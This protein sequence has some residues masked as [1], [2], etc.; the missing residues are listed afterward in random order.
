M[1]GVEIMSRA[2]LLNREII[3]VAY[4]LTVGC[5]SMVGWTSVVFGCLPM[6]GWTSVVFGCLKSADRP[7]LFLHLLFFLRF[8]RFL[9]LKSP[10]FF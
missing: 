1:F 10:L 9:R 8:S 4:S 3:V 6:V 5:V 7:L 2:I